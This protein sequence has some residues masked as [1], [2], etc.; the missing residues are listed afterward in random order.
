MGDTVCYKLILFTY[1]VY[2]QKTH[3]SQRDKKIR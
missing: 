3:V 2:E 1:S